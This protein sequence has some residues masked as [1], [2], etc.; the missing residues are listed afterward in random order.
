M[1]YF[2]VPFGY[3]HGEEEFHTILKM[4]SLRKIRKERLR[5]I[6]DQQF[7]GRGGQALLAQVLERQTGYVSRCLSGEKPI[8]EVFARHVERALHLPRYWLDGMHVDGRMISAQQAA[9]LERFDA[10][11]PSQQREVLE[12]LEQTRRRN[13]EIHEHLQRRA[14]QSTDDAA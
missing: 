6:L 7:P 13:Q 8:G 2:H 3:C 11:T 5:Q 10:L 12:S 4:E 1:T 9:L 14:L